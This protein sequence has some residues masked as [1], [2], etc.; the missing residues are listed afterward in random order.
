MSELPSAEVLPCFRSCYSC[1]RPSIGPPVSVCKHVNV[2]LLPFVS[3]FV[4]LS[5]GLTPTCNYGTAAR[6]DL[7][8][9]AVSDW[10]TAASVV[11]EHHVRFQD[12]SV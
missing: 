11:L 3:D 12:P 10:H 7:P 4:R 9:A 8:T 6:P 5:F 1:Y 2:P